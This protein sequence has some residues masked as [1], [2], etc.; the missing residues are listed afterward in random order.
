M[1]ETRV[2]KRKKRG[3]GLLVIAGL[4][5]LIMAVAFA[6]Y[7]TLSGG[8]AKDVVVIINK[9][10]SSSDIAAVLADHDVIE[11]AFL[12]KFYI[13]RQDAQDRLQAGEYNLKTGM[14]YSEALA[15]LLKG[16]AAKHYTVLIPEGL[17]VAK[18]AEAVAKASPI[19]ESDFVDAARA[20]LYDYDFLQDAYEN[21]LEGYLF[22]KTYT[23][24][25]KTTAKDMINMMLRQFKTETE[26]L[27]LSYASQRGL[28]LG[29]VVIAASIIETEVKIP[30]ERPLVSAVI[31]NRL[32]R[33]MYLQMCSTVEFALPER[34]DELSYIDLE[35]ESPYNTYLH[36]GLP[37]GPIASPGLASLLAAAQPA[38]VDYLYYVLTGSDGSHTFTASYDEFAKV[39]E[40][41]GL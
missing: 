24:T 16:P 20:D 7:F 2:I 37:P 29:Q 39:K 13:R 22:P 26:G 6:G 23:I 36:P 17:T 32:A 12:F 30:D 8:P 25:D 27:D 1:T 34:K 5:L 28:G 4:A 15:A 33:E 21:S 38:P 9:G 41:R 11:N 3:A 18:T 14:S 35:Y 40:E 31:Y 10:A 19:K